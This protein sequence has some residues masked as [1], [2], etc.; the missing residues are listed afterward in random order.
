MSSSTRIWPSQA[1]LAPMPMV[2]I[3]H[4]AGDAAG[5]RLGH[6]LDHQREGAGVGDRLRVVL[7]R[8]P[9]ASSRPWARNEPMRV[10]RLR[11][12]ADMAHHRHA[13]LGEEARS[14]PPCARPPSTLMAPQPVS[15]ITRAAFMKA[16]SFEAS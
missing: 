15:F 16:C 14:S 4:R 6:R 3:A 5:E 13:A 1:A 7:D 2:G 12:E 8:P 9:V 10:D 11:R